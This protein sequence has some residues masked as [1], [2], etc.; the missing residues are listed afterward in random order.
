MYWIIVFLLSR[1]IT[2]TVVTISF[3]P[4]HLICSGL[5]SSFT[6]PIALAISEKWDAERMMQ[7]NRIML[8]KSSST[9]F[10]QA[11][12]GVRYPKTSLR[13]LTA[14]LYFSAIAD[15]KGSICKK[16]HVDLTLGSTCPPTN[17]SWSNKECVWREPLLESVDRHRSSVGY[18][19][20][21]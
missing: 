18:Q 19:I 9:F 6:R 14:C 7:S 15:G 11:I 2:F 8:K 13:S 1:S 10:M 12:S 16:M 5:I 4:S 21:N 17:L 20:E 3:L